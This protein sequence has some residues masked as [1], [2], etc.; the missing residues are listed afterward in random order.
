MAFTIPL[1]KPAKKLASV[2]PTSSLFGIQTLSSVVG[3]L[4]INFIFTVI[5]LGTLFGQSWFHC[6]TWDYT[7]S[8]IGN[9]LIIGDNYE[10]ETLFLVT[11]FQYIIS[12]A[13]YTFGNKFRLPWYTNY[14]FVFFA[15]LWTTLHFVSTLVPSR[16]SCLWRVNCTNEVSIAVYFQYSITIVNLE[17]SRLILTV[18]YITPFSSFF[19][20]FVII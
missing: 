10:S 8:G 5:A 16:L 13:V 18:H 11:G 1:S 4:L 9:I 7:E 20:P 6:R 12:A 14:W 19:F 3:I 2:F 15:T 17:Y